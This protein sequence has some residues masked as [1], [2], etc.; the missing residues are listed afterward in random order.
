MSISLFSDHRVS[1][2]VCLLQTF[3]IL[4]FLEIIEIR[5]LKIGYDWHPL[6]FLFYSLISTFSRLFIYIL[7]ES[8]AV[9]GFV[10]A[11]SFVCEARELACG[12][13]GNILLAIRDILQPKIQLFA[14][15]YL[16]TVIY[17]IHISNRTSFKSRTVCCVFGNSDKLYASCAHHFSPRATSKRC[18]SNVNSTSKSP[19]AEWRSVVALSRRWVEQENGQY[20]TCSVDPVLLFLV[21]WCPFETWTELVV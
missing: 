11:S 19:P 21:F 4:F 9:F 15:I 13:G 8:P 14:V 7:T 10:K 1:D 16:Y 6:R 5:P 3:K 12:G 17:F 18:H 20:V 2:T